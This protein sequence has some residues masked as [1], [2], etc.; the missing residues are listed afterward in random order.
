MSDSIRRVAGSGHDEMRCR[1]LV[2]VVT[3]YLEDRLPEVDRLRLAAHLAECPYCEEYIAQMRRTIE[4][5]GELPVETIVARRRA[6]LLEV[7]RAWRR[8]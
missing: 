7:F 1:E 4:I 6:E 8:V 3:D 2:E 5:L